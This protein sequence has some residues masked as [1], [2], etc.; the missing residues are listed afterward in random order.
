MKEDARTF[1]ISR[2]SK[3]VEDIAELKILYKFDVYSKEHL[4]KVLPSYEFRRNGNYHKFEEK[5]LFEFIDKFPL[6]NLVFFTEGDW[7]DIDQHD[8][9]FVGLLYLTKS[10]V[11][12]LKNVYNPTFKDNKLFAITNI[13]DDFVNMSEILLSFSQIKMEKPEYLLKIHSYSDDFFG[14]TGVT[15]FCFFS[16]KASSRHNIVENLAQDTEFECD[17]HCGCDNFALAA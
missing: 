5:L 11:T 14:H 9:E 17:I 12:N 7:I 6:D 1:I 4:I 8:Q 13:S 2:L 10:I 3:L 15:D 16:K